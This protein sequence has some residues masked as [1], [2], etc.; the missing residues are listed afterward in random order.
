MSNV[1]KIEIKKSRQ[2][3]MSNV[4]K[5]EIKKSRQELMS[6]VCKINSEVKIKRLRNQ[7]K[8]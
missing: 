3:L 6:N 7:D 1:C 2:E 8:N 5:I 4:C